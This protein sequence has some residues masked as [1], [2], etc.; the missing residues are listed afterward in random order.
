[1]NCDEFVGEAKANIRTLFKQDEDMR[2]EL[3]KLNENQQG[4]KEITII[5]KLQQQQYADQHELLGSMHSN[6]IELNGTVRTL[7]T[8]MDNVKNQVVNIQESSKFDMR[9]FMKEFTYKVLPTALGTLLVAWIL[10]KFH[11]S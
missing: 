3:D 10:W 11:W 9:K 6:L 1:M 7:Q 5:L 4:L 8:D 2:H